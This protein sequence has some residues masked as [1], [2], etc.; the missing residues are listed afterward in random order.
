MEMKGIRPIHARTSRRKQA[1]IRLFFL[2]IIASA[3]LL[4]FTA[5]AFAATTYSVPGDFASI[6]AAIDSPTVLNGDTISVEPGTYNENINIHKSLT[7]VGSATPGNKTISAA[8]GTAVTITAD[9]VTIDGFTI[10]NPSGKH[11]ISAVDHSNLTISNNVIDDIGSG[12]VSVSGT[13]FAIA[14]VSSAAAVD[15]IN[16]TDNQITQ[17]AGGPSK[18]ANGI[19]AGWSTGS[20]DITNL[21]IQGNA[22]SDVTSDTTAWPVGH[23]AYGII[24]NHGTGVTGKT[25]APQILDNEI[26][27]LEGLWAH[28]IGLEGN[29][30]NALVQGNI[31]HGLVD[32]KS[33]AD[34]DA[35]AI[36]VEDNASADSVSIT[37]NSFF[38]V[39]LGIRNATA[40][41]VNAQ[42]NWWGD[43]DPSDDVYNPGGGSVDYS[44]WMELPLGTS[45]MTWGTSDSVQ[46][47]VDLASDG[48]TINVKAGNVTGANVDKDL[49]ITGEPGAVINSGPAYGTYTECNGHLADYGFQILGPGGSGTTISNLRFETVSFPVYGRGADDVTISGN[50]LIN[51]LQGISNKA[52]GTSGSRWTVS[53]NEIQDLRANNGGGIAII[54]SDTS[55]GV[56]QDNVIS[57][58]SITGTLHVN[59]CESGGYEGTGIVIYADFRWYPYYSGATDISGNQVL[60]NDINLVSDNQAVLGVSGIELTSAKDALSPPLPEVPSVV[61]GNTISGNN[62]DGSLAY[63][64]N[65]I[66]ASDNSITANTIMNAANGISISESGGGSDGICYSY[67]NTV[68]SNTL[69]GNA[70]QATISAGN[71]GNNTDGNY[72]SDF[73]GSAPYV[74]SGGQDNSPSGP[75]QVTYVGPTGEV[76]VGDPLVTATAT[77]GTG[78]GLTIELGLAGQL[79][80]VNPWDITLWTFPC[81]VDGGGNVSCPTN[82][83][84]EGDYTATVTV[85]DSNGLSGD[86]TGNFNIVDDAPPVT[87][88]DAPA[89]W[90]NS[91][92]TVTLTCTDAV[93]G[94][95]TTEWSADNGGGSGTGNTVVISNEGV[96]TITYHSTDNVGH[97]EA[98]KTATVSIDK[99]DP[100]VTYTG[101]TGTV[102][103]NLTSITG[104]VS[105]AAPSSGIDASTGAVLSLDGG[106]TYP[107]SCTVTPGGDIDCP[108]SSLANGSYTAVISVNDQAGNN[109]TDSGAFTYA[110]N[111]KPDLGVSVA[112]VYWVSY[113]DYLAG[114]LSVDYMLHNGSTGLTA[115]DVE[116]VGAIN[117]N[118]VVLLTTTPVA[119]GNIAAG[120][121]A[122]FTLKY[123]LPGGA[124][125]FLSSLYA[126]A[127]DPTGT[128]YDYPGP[129]PGP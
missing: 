38:D 107:Y 97:V 92:V 64:L 70:V 6:Q 75:P 129:Y 99:T 66:G 93:S 79:D 43:D 52:Q 123:G 127:S 33:P 72:W 120:A 1:V 63:G 40:L 30:P 19:A 94:C 36:M 80:P 122:G 41:T 4:I 18:S 106:A 113:A 125:Q 83:L 55:L 115:M 25:D 114:N 118:S 14:V 78:G 48:D 105:D 112:K 111:G 117:T 50:T 100:V 29:T 110:A 46:E 2:A 28:G 20:S 76:N 121:D 91:D 24:I 37:G 65:V 10:T 16:I 71:T 67:N 23:G 124:T 88:D 5:P 34:P 62:L 39:W 51:P 87:T 86:A 49:T 74:F 21:L 17:I 35:A 98:G 47:A 81:T 61:T 108:I 27:N 119:V 101:P 8:G 89:G 45:P 3:A 59:A 54:M 82:G 58:N 9:G 102:Y 95:D 7:I 44:P 104:T 11:G 77:D 103:T 22:I 56:V 85:Y 32:H 109:G 31:I 60:N 53:G 96:T 126:T 90:Q 116:I 84:P 57:G 13:N 69:I 26:S 15:S 68:G 12:D 73:T 128:S 42:G